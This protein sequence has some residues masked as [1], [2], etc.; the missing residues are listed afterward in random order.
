M[1]YIIGLLLVVCAIASSIAV[2]AQK[3]GDPPPPEPSHVHVCGPFEGLPN[4]IPDH[5]ALVHN[6]GC[7]DAITKPTSYGYYSVYGTRL[8]IGLEN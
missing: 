6:D 3:G 2:L 4:T 8:V 5:V 1:R 7:A